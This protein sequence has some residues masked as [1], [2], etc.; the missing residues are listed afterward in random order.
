MSFFALSI[1]PKYRRSVLIQGVDERFKELVK[2][3][4]DSLLRSVLFVRGFL[5]SPYL[6]SGAPSH[7][8]TLPCFLVVLTTAIFRRQA[9][10]IRGDGREGNCNRGIARTAQ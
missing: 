7:P 1:C 2:D 5:S 8:L 4:N 9:T 10:G 6:K 3:L